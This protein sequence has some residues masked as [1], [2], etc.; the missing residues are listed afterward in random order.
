VES[1]MLESLDA[2]CEGLMLKRLD[3]PA[4]AYSPSK[5]ADSWL[6]V[7]KDYCEELRDSLDLVCIG[8]W[9]GNGRKAG[10]FSPFLLAVWDPEREEYSSMCR[11]MTGFTDAFYADRTERFSSPEILL[12]SR[13]PYYHTLES[14]D[15]WFAPTEVWEVRGADLTL[16]PKH[17]A[18]AGMRHADRGISLRFPRFI[19]HRADKS[20]EDA[21]GPAEVVALYDAQQ[22]RF[23]GQGAAAA[24]RLQDTANV[25]ATNAATN[26]ATKMNG[27]D[28]EDDG[29]DDDEDDGADSDGDE[30]GGGG[31][32]DGED[33]ER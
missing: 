28:D 30:G 17:R 31:D 23:D 19:S 16:S 29:E 33:D 21:S 22:R 27:E 8:A 12:P 1:F 20:V 25:A 9:R 14:P 18:A 15:V 7:K 11:C 5:R 6:K 13:P 24:R 32:M 3:G 26:A 10:W 4:S 2:A